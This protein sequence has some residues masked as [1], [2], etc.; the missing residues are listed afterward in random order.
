MADSKVA[1][2]EN[3][4]ASKNEPP[5]PW[6]LGVFDAHCHPT[7][8]V[9]SLDSIPSMKARVLTIM[10]TRGQDQA[11]V[12]RF[13]DR[14][15]LVEQEKESII[16]SSHYKNS[17]ACRVIPSFGWHPWF[18][19]QLYDDTHDARLE[20]GHVSSSSSSSSVDKFKH[21]KSVIFKPGP[22]EYDDAFLSALPNPRPLS[23]YLEQTR[24]FLIKY[25]FALVG[26]IGIDRSFR[27]PTNWMP[28]DAVDRDPNL[29]PG[30]RE[31]RKL[32]PYRV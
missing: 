11:L 27:L 1:T 12:A 25:P 26:E 19:H 28:E 29:T 15:G 7:D 21:Y 3:N 18:S 22:V 23:E 9:A 24:S 14:L 20:A 32:S 5:F 2:T 4:D 13:A 30:G 10:A 16:H 6:H 8:T 17:E 31:G